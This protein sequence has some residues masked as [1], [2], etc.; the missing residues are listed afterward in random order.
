MAA[1]HNLCNISKF[2]KWIIGMTQV[3]SH[4][5]PLKL[6][7]LVLCDIFRGNIS[8]SIFFLF[9]F[10]FFFSNPAHGFVKIVMW[11]G[12]RKLRLGYDAGMRLL[13]STRALRDHPSMDSVT[14]S[15]SKEISNRAC[16]QSENSRTRTMPSPRN[17][18]CSSATPTGYDRIAV[19]KSRLQLEST[20]CTVH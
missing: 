16:V 18:S 2:R 11:I 10:F 19:H 20:S 3:Y 5:M 4:A 13:D 15:A 7:C 14:I 1:A 9:S 17:M 8:Q 6:F 12:L